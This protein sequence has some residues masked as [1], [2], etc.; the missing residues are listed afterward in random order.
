MQDMNLHI[1]EAQQSPSGL[2]SKRS[3]LR[4]IIIKLSNTKYKERPDSSKREVN[5]HLQ[6]PSIILTADFLSET[7]KHQ[8]Y[9][10]K[11]LREKKVLPP[12]SICSTAILQK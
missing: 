1:Q 9:I 4:H 11:M 8:N 7:M 2:Y 12:N 10:L 5:H 3:T 6:G